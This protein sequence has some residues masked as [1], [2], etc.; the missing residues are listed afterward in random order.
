MD[1]SPSAA[2]VTG[3]SGFIGQ[4]LIRRLSERGQAVRALARSDDA[5]AEV[6]QA[7]AE[8]VRGDLEDTAALREGATGCEGAY[9]A[10]ARLG[11]WGRWE[12]FE[13]ITVQATRNAL[14]ACREA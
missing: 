6:A 7:G 13:R 12:D 5:A 8:P 9:H 2:F 11:A 3:G 14:D 1:S 10:A 4:A